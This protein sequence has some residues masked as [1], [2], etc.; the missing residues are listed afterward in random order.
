MADE[1]YQWLD[2]DAAEKLLRGD[3]VEPVDDHAARTDAQ[4]LAAALG[5]A[6]AVRPA[7]GELPGEA[8]ALAAF[9]EASRARREGA[10][11]RRT[12]ATGRDVTAGRAGT[13]LTVRVGA[14]HSA[15]PRRP[16]WSRPLRYGLVASLAGCALG[17]VAVAASTGMI[18]GP[19]GGHSSPVPAASVSAAASP[20]ELGSGLPSGGPSVTPPGSPATSE[21]AAP[22]DTADDAESATDAGGA[23]PSGPAGGSKDTGT[24]GADGNADSDASRNVTGGPGVP[25]D[26]TDA[27]A[28]ELYEKT[29]RECRDYR[30]GTLD[31]RSKRRLIRLAKGEGNLDRFCDRLLDEAGQNGDGGAGNDSG[32][33]DGGGGDDGDTGDGSGGSLPSVSFDKSPTAVA[34]NGDADRVAGDASSSAPT[35]PSASSGAGSEPTATGSAALTRSVR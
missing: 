28:R 35:A 33:N 27:E 1:R 34:A 8:R 12:A 11:G 15:A 18:S 17:G 9:R 32:G 19:F 10:A 14:G 20:E 7:S 3:F 24:A 13:L 23:G 25:G 31:N 5:E 16:R 30:E 22:S 21:S 6:R 26:S 2:V 4:R 29:V